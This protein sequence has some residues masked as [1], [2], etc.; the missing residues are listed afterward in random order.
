[1]PLSNMIET[2]LFLSNRFLLQY[3]CHSSSTYHPA[4]SPGHF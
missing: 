3:S 2:I 4:H 1:M